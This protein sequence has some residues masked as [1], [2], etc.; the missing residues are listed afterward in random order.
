MTRT[1]VFG[2]GVCEIARLVDGQIVSDMVDIEIPRA[3][4][5]EKFMKGVKAENPDC[6]INVLGDVKFIA[7]TYRINEE[8]F[9]E[10]ASLC[11]EKE[12]SEGFGSRK[13]KEV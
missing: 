11:G 8:E 12:V 13:K 1:L 5:K 6:L 7:R 2:V 10:K 3:N 9:F 4:T